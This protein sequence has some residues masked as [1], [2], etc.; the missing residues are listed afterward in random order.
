MSARP[1]RLSAYASNFIRPV[2]L[3][4][5]APVSSR[6]SS[7]A[8]RSASASVRSGASALLSRLCTKP[9]WSRETATEGRVSAV[10]SSV[11]AL[12]ALVRAAASYVWR[13]R[14]GRVPSRTAWP[15]HAPWSHAAALIARAPP[16]LSLVVVRR[17][18]SLLWGGSSKQG[19]QRSARAQNTFIAPGP[20]ST[21]TNEP[22]LSTMRSTEVLGK[23]GNPMRAL[24]VAARRL[25]PSLPPPSPATATSPT[26]LPGRPPRLPPPS[27]PLSRQSAPSAA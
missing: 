21:E 20:P 18:G 27:P 10:T 9:Y 11:C 14:R 5:L 17:Y 23:H 4:P 8:A 7:S 3:A 13:S 22:P 19:A 12:C 1:K 16:F 6:Q 24:A 2:S 26:A 25:A 15:Q